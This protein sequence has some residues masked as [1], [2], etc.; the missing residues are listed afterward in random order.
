MP[1]LSTVN[2]LT[3]VLN[4]GDVSEIFL[5]CLN[6]QTVLNLSKV[7]KVVNKLC[8]FRALLERK[9]VRLMHGKTYVSTP[10][11]WFNHIH[12]L[13][14]ER[15]SPRSKTVSLLSNCCNDTAPGKV[16]ASRKRV[17]LVDGVES[18]MLNR[19]WKR[20]R[21]YAKD[22]YSPEMD[23]KIESENLYWNLYK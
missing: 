22:L 14:I 7:S 16:F 6:Y 19:D 17:R 9:T 12:V 5:D 23:A 13:T 20:G 4:H 8:D 15:K 2:L 1:F 10:T 11:G 3:N 18:V 21:I